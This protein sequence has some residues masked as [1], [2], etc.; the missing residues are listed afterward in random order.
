MLNCNYFNKPPIESYRNKFISDLNL[1]YPF[2]KVSNTFKSLCSRDISVITIGN[3]ENSVLFSGAYHGMEWIT[4]LL[5]LKFTSR[6][7]SKISQKTK[8]FN[9]DISKFITSRGVTIIPCVN[10]DGVE[11]SLRGAK[12]AGKY[13]K[14]VQNISHG[15]TS[16]WQSNARGVD[17]NHNF[18]ADWQDLHLREQQ[19]GFTGPSHTRFGGTHPESEPETQAITKICR[20]NNFTHALAFHSQGEEIYWNYGKNTPQKS[21]FMA[22]VLSSVTNYKVCSPEGLAVGG[23]FKDWFITEFKKPGFTIEIGKG[24]NPLPI[25]DFDSIYK[26]LEYMMLLSIII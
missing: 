24:K 21:E 16:N 25:S 14:L 13:Y 10:P 17:L 20:E 26:K 4:T 8:F 18:N 2:I 19:S 12:Y 15:D 9:I 11:I 6:L 3:T 5:L 7:C 22:K 23:G 1:K